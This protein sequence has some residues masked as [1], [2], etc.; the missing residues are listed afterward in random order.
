MKNTLQLRRS[1]G[2]SRESKPGLT[3]HNDLGAPVIPP[4]FG[5][6]NVLWVANYASAVGPFMMKGQRSRV[7]AVGHFRLPT[8]LNPTLIVL[9]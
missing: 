6:I 2:T 4:K 7:E 8:N 3:E 9:R 5:S 1:G